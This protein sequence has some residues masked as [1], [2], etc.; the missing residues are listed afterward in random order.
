[1]MFLVILSGVT[2]STPLNKIYF[3]SADTSSISGARSI[4]QWTYFY[5]CGANNQDCGIA[6]AGLPIGYAW[7]GT[8]QTNVPAG[9]TGSYAQGTTSMYYFYMWRFGWVFYLMGLA[10]AAMALLTGFISFLKLGSAVSSFLALSATF[11]TTLAACLM[12]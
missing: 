3:L 2:N 12:T 7:V 6:T 1:M 8:S 10:F 11:W 5:V 9:L 4:S